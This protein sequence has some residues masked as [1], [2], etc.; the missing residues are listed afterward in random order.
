MYDY[1]ILQK[2]LE[3]LKQDSFHTAYCQI[4]DKR[5]SLYEKI[6]NDIFVIKKDYCIEY[7]TVITERSE[8]IFYKGKD[9]FLYD[10]F[11]YQSTTKHEYEM[12]LRYIGHFFIGA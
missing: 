8:L 6:I 4:L 1:Y 10:L 5:T 11:K 3:K 12:I 2:E 7:S 9:S